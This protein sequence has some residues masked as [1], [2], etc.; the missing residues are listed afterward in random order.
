[1]PQN[2]EK[3]DALLYIIYSQRS[4]FASMGIEN[5]AFGKC[6]QSSVDSRMELMNNW[7]VML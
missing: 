6:F 3:K 5:Q 4:W 2:K 1:M 7:W